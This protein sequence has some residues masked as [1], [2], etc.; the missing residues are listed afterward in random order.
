ML[1]FVATQA[2]ALALVAGVA[3]ARGRQLDT[4]RDALRRPAPGESRAAEESA[5]QA[6]REP[7]TEIRRLRG[8]L[9]RLGWDLDQQ[10]RDTAYLADLVGV[11]IVHLDEDLWA[12]FG[13]AAAHVFL[14]RQPGSMVGRPVLEAVADPRVEAIVV[15][16]R[17]R[18]SASGEV[19][20]RE[21][22]GAGLLVRAR[23][24][25]VRGT[26]LVLEDV[27][28]LRRLQR[29]RREFIDNLSHEL[30]TPLTTIGL[31]AE[32]LGRDAENV[33]DAIPPRMRDRIGRIEIETGHLA[34]MVTE[35]LDLAEIEGGA[36][37]Q[38]HL[39]DVDL[40]SVASA[41]VDRLRLFAERNG[42]QLRVE[43]TV[44]RC[45]PV[46]GDAG[47]LGQ[48]FI[49]LIHNAIKFS[50]SGAEVVV[51]VRLVDGEIVATVVDHGVGIPR[52]EQARIF[53]RFYKVDRA[54]GKGGGTGLGLSIARHVV[55]AH[56]GRIWVESE[57]GEGSTF[58]F[59]LPAA[60]PPPARAVPR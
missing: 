6:I 4:V 37:G 43:P 29:M 9:E 32:T 35:L 12:D 27:A 52:A 47:R 2:V 28:E 23:R 14:G 45:P 42:I 31:L 58:S 30:R 15:A 59:A 53:E 1:L 50:P 22:D 20:V 57:E 54:R 10:R 3:I 39:D 51:G 33:G 48:V 41:S 40:A 24:S 26:W 16:A 17:D 11:G 55:E 46:R 49:N 18:G 60:P 36:E 7:A 56:G 13:N 34:Q 21:R 5:W 25:P 19:I 8:E 38:L 44:G